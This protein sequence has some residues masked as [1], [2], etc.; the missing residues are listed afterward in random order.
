MKP[1]GS[2][3]LRSLR[4]HAAEV[5]TGEDALRVPGIGKFIATKLEEVL[6]RH[7]EDQHQAGGGH[8]NIVP[9]Q[10][11]G[12][13]RADAR[14]ML[15]GGDDGGI[16]GEDALPSDESSAEGTCRARPL[17]C[18]RGGVHDRPGRS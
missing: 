5:R 13:L 9:P 3:A 14:Q 6:K 12:A 4:A 11:A 8:G 16:G 15:H 1:D 18:G 7:H 17:A 2:Q 10:P